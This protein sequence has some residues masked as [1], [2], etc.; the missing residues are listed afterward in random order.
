M[1]KVLNLLLTFAVFFGGWKI[2]PEIFQFRDLGAVVITVLI[3]YAISAVY[4]LIIMLIGFYAVMSQNWK[5]IMFLI[6]AILGVFILNIVSILLISKFYSGFTFNGGI[7]ALLLTA[8]ALG[9]FS[10]DVNTTNNKQT[11]VRRYY[12]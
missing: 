1:K 7:G 8:L 5:A 10:V 9:L 4:V 12:R 6:F 2:F 11:E 3:R